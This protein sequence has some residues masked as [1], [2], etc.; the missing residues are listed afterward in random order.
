MTLGDNKKIML[1]LIEEYSPE[2]EI[3]TTDEDI[4]TRLNLVYAPSYQYAAQLKKILRTKTIVVNEDSD[5]VLEQILP[6]NMYQLKRIIGLDDN[7]NKI[8]AEYDIIGNKIYLKQRKGKYIMEYYAYPLQI[9]AETPDTFMLEIDNDAQAVLPYMV[10]NDILKVDPS[11]DYTAFLAEYK[12]RM[13]GLD[14]RKATS[15]A[16]VEVICDI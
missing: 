11:A 9:T 3:L 10:A 6:G 1:A 13:Q 16:E 14:P 2:S 8:S 7:N 4:A 5:A 15:S 12:S